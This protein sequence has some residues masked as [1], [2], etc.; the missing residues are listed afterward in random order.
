MENGTLFACGS[1]TQSKAH[2]LL[3][4]IFISI[5]IWTGNGENPLKHVSGEMF[6]V[7]LQDGANA[8]HI[9]LMYSSKKRIWNGQ[10]FLHKIACVLQGDQLTRWFHLI[11]I[12]VKTTQWCLDF[13][14]AHIST[15]FLYLKSAY[16]N[17][18]RHKSLI[19]Q[20]CRILQIVKSFFSETFISHWWKK[21]PVSVLCNNNIFCQ[22]NVSGISDDFWFL[23]CFI[24]CFSSL[25]ERE[26]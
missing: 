24:F 22:R 2:F 23:R 26:K 11:Y 13:S 19:T 3:E 20:L 14:F 9:W 1:W 4:L 21:S 7:T 12:V 17:A 8:F 10:E 5:T 6:S 18:A 15:M 16:L 25:Q